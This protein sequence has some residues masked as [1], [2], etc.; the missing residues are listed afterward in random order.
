LLHERLRTTE[1]KAKE[2]KRFADK[3]V[4][5]GKRGTLHARRRALQIGY[6]ESVVRKLFDELAVRYRERPG[7]YTRIMKLG[8][9]PGDGAEM[10]LIELVDAQIKE[11]A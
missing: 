1:A 6:S 4:T 2:L 10:A 3:M 7:G 11:K 9:R 5:L 8:P